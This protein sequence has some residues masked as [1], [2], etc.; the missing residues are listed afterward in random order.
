LDF[1]LLW[2]TAF[3]SDLDLTVTT[4]KGKV[5][6]F[7]N[8]KAAGCQHT[9]D[10]VAQSINKGTPQGEEHVLCNNY[11]PG[12]YTIKVSQK[13]SKGG[14]NTFVQVVRDPLKNGERIALFQTT[15]DS[16]TPTFTR[17]VN[18][19]PPGSSSAAPPARRR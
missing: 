15:I 7:E 6:S 10:E 4:P 14:S 1:T 5:I 12:K 11:L 3:F 17:V 9:G 13:S 16:Q 18:V 8:P 19:G 2:T